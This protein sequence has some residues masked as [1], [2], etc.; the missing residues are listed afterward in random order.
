MPNKNNFI[1]KAKTNKK[2]EFYTM[3]CDIEKE[4]VHYENCFQGKI[5][6]CKCIEEYSSV[7]N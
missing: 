3:M 7:K 2:D 4:M 6:Y 5:V 1:V